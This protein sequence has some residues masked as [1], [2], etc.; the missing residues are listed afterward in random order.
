MNVG[1]ATA[2]IEKW[3]RQTEFKSLDPFAHLG[4]W[5]TRYALIPRQLRYEAF[6]RL[7]PRCNQKFFCSTTHAF[8][9]RAGL[10]DLPEPEAPLGLP[11]QASKTKPG[12]PLAIVMAFRSVACLEAGLKQEGWDAIEELKRLTNDDGSVFFSKE[13]RITPFNI[14]S[15]TALAYHTAGERDLSARS[16]DYACLGLRDDGFLQY[17]ANCGQTDVVHSAMFY[18]AAQQIKPNEFNEQFKAFNDKAERAPKNLWDYAKL[19]EA[20]KRFNADWSSAWIKALELFDSQAGAFRFSRNTGRRYGVGFADEL[21]GRH[22]ALMYYALKL[23]GAEA[24][25]SVS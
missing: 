5:E 6:L 18:C 21:Y 8:L 17:A 24:L 16:L 1:D 9:L 12:T 2:S 11:F 3:F 14:A 19:I 23:N 20:R 22:N 15:E 13:N 25:K 7:K 4:A 10:N